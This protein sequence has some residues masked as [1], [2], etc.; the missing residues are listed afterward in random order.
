LLAPQKREAKAAAASQPQPA[1]PLT[2]LERQRAASIVRNHAMMADLGIGPGSAG[3]AAAGK[4]PALPSRSSSGGVAVAVAWQ[5]P[6]RQQSGVPLPQRDTKG[7]FLPAA[8]AVRTAVL[9]PAVALVDCSAGAADLT[10]QHQ[11]PVE[12]EAAAGWANLGLPATP[13]QAAERRS[14]RDKRSSRKKSGDRKRQHAEAG[15]PPAA[16]KV[17]RTDVQLV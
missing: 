9:P 5:P 10:L 16:P 3:Q 7:R 12:L 2:P 4:L 17:A 6:P 14:G 1:E 11:A 15:E 13:A 8:Q